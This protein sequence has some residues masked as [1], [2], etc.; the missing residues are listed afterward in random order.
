MVSTHL[1]NTSQNWIISPNRDEHKQYLKPPPGYWSM[2][3]IFAYFVGT[4]DQSKR[5]VRL[6][7]S[8]RRQGSAP[9]LVGDTDEVPATKGTPEV[10]GFEFKMA[11]V[12]PKNVARIQL[13]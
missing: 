6:N 1:K 11:R 7:D 2:V 9:F 5:H 13:S 8:R 12:G 10:K 4:V 3:K